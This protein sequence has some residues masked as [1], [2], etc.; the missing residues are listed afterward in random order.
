MR[1]PFC[2][3]RTAT[4]ENVMKADVTRWSGIAFEADTMA[5]AN[6]CYVAVANAAGFDGVYSY[7]GHS[8]IVGFDGRTLGEC[9]EE[10]YGIQYAAL[11]T[12]LI[13]DARRNMQ[14]QN[15]LFK[16]VHRGYTGKINSGEDV[17]GEAVCPYDFYKK[18]I[19]DPKGTREMVEALTRPTVGTEECPIDGIPAKKVA[20]R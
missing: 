9:G 10:D 5:W 2:S 18:W 14:S 15:H 8:A 17:R 13:R 20:H 6:N 12:S 7:F 11:S 16:L 19:T 3:A 1:F 4:V